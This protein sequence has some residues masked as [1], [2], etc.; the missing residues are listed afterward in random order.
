[1]LSLVPA[2][3]EWAELPGAPPFDSERS[4]IISVLC[5]PL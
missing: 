1:L 5:V 3:I 2:G 4:R